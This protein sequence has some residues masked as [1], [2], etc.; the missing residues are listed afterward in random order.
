MPGYIIVIPFLWT[1]IGFSAAFTLGIYEDTALIIS[2]LLFAVL[3]FI[4]PKHPI[5]KR[6]MGKPAY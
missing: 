3:N 4:K 2:G 6:K 1:I 5:L